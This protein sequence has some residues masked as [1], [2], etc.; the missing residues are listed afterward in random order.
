MVTDLRR[1]ASNLLRRPIFADPLVQWQADLVY[2]VCWAALLTMVLSTVAS[3]IY[4]GEPTVA[5]WTT[6]CLTAPLL[7][8]LVLTRRGKIRPAAWVLSLS[9]YAIITVT[10]IWFADV[11]DVVHLFGT[12]TFIA[13]LVLGSKALV[14]LSALGIVL[15]VV[16]VL[17][18]ADGQL[19]PPIHEGGVSN[20]II[21][22]VVGVVMAAWIVSRAVATVRRARQAWRKTNAELQ[23]VL[24]SLEETIE[25]RTADLRRVNARLHDEVAV[26]NLIQ[27]DLVDARDE[28]EAAAE[29]KAQ[30][31]AN[32][33]HEIRTPL[34]GIIGVADLLAH[35]ELPP[36]IMRH[37]ETIQISGELMM[38]LVEDVLDFSHLEAEGPELKEADFNLAGVVDAAI[39]PIRMDARERGLALEVAVDPALPARLR[40]DPGRLA[41]VLTNLAGNAVKFT[42]EGT[43]R[44]EARAVERTSGELRVGFRV[45]DTGVGMTAEQ[46]ERVFEPFVQADSSTTRRYGGTGLGLTI[47]KRLVEHMGGEL[48]VSSELGVGSVFEFVLPLVASH[49]SAEPAE[50]AEQDAPWRPDP[51]GVSLHVL[52]VEDNVINQKVTTAMLE[53]LG[54]RHALADD[55]ESALELLARFPFDVVLMDCQMPGMDGLEACRRLRASEGP[56][57][58]VPVVALTAHESAEQREATAAV[59]MDV[60]LAKPVRFESLGTLLTGIEPRTESNDERR[61]TAEQTAEPEGDAPSTAFATELDQS[62]L[63]EL[64][65]LEAVRP[66][67]LAK[68]ARLYLD[69]MPTRLEA[70]FSADEPAARADAAH[71]LKGSS[72]SLGATSVGQ[73]AAAIEKAARAGESTDAL[74]PALRE[75][76]D[77][78]RPAMQALVAPDT[79][80]S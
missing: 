35:E 70:V 9:S 42:R 20:S 25:K 14:P 80:R 32:V 1:S 65:A 45:G 57:R 55:G 38:G 40:G 46:V 50:G 76:F 47:A 58:D 7:V 48:R 60:F 77:A 33:S 39:A 28:A 26:R 44:I 30:F 29:A 15:V 11:Y 3:V 67:V 71:V 6:F 75:A 79:T 61:M 54:H 4:L 72:L 2:P 63:G 21:A 49:P 43:I 18:Q 59:G 24:S 31:V 74:L 51:C 36:A 10:A 34:N 16:L 22:L 23:S 52:V 64:R 66:G 53:R 41:Q 8:S 56:N 12:A 62:M 13:G 17:A 5:S 19:P 69:H 37:V 73:A 27:A 78:I 68:M